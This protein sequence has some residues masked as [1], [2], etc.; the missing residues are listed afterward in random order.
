M[1]A[2]DAAGVERHDRNIWADPDAAAEVREITGGNETVPCVRIGAV[3]LV[4][5]SAKK[6]LRLLKTSET[7]ARRSRWRR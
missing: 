7:P 4:N 6:V 1:A 5:P 2:L 3:T